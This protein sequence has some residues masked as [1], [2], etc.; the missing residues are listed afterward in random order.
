LRNFILILRQSLV[1]HIIQLLGIIPIV[2][3][4]FIF[5]NVYYWMCWVV[6]LIVL[7][8]YYPYKVVVTKDDITIFYLIFRTKKVKM[9]DVYELSFNPSIYHN[10]KSFNLVYLKRGY[11]KKLILPYETLSKAA[12]L[13][14]VIK[15]MGK[16]VDIIGFKS[17]K[18]NSEGKFIISE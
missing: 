13:S 12:E 11:K 17:I 16:R 18:I 1:G 14:N 4:M 15:M 6:L 5:K 10:Y 7:F 8:L 2:L 3:T 9:K